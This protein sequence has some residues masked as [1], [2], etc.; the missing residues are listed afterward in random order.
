M[1]R[2]IAK[3]K[4]FYVSRYEIGSSGSSVQNQPVLNA[5][6]SSVKNWYGLYDASRNTQENK[7]MHSHMI[8][9]CQYDQIMK[10]AK[11]KTR[12]DGTNQILDVLVGSVVRQKKSYQNTGINPA[13]K[14]CNIYDLEG[15]YYE[16]TAQVESTSSRVF[17]G[18]GAYSAGRGQFY[19]AAT[20]Q[21]IQSV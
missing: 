11:E 4:G 13:D 15:N 19:P 20:S 8:W 9:G 6:A 16:W 3:Y 7:T 2:S 17:R 12:Y 21:R 14:V 5:G 1:A 10:F 18:R